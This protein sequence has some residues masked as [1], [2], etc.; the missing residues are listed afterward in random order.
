MI[1]ST[2]ALDIESVPPRLV[3]VGGG[4]IGL[5]F[6]CIYEALGSKV[7]VLELTSGH[8]SRRD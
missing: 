1:T 4:V 7:T 3:I 2:G 8:S 5:E 6:A